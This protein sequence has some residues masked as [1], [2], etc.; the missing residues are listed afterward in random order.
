MTTDQVPAGEYDPPAPPIFAERPRRKG[1]RVVEV[2]EAGHS[3]KGLS[4][5]EAA[6]LRY[7]SLHEQPRRVRRVVK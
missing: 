5:D 3:L 2:F 7:E 1:L 6:Q 4:A